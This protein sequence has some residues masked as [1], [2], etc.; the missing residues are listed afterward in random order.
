MAAELEV[1][2][3]VEVGHGRAFSCISVNVDNGR[4][5]GRTRQAFKWAILVATSADAI[6]A[7]KRRSKLSNL[8]LGLSML[9]VVIG[10]IKVESCRLSPRNGLD[11]CRQVG[12]G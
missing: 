5:G 11:R 8:L 3:V 7:P 2:E 9:V 12:D 4:D 6:S 10:W 1:L